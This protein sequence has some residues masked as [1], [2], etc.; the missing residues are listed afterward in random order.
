MLHVLEP[1]ARNFWK[2]WGEILDE[3]GW[4]D[5]SPKTDAEWKTVEDGAATALIVGDLL[6]S[7]SYAKEPRDDWEQQVQAF[8]TIASEARIQAMKQN[9]DA[10]FDLGERLD[11]SCDTCHAQFAPHVP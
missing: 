5:I 9:S 3:N 11:Q 6:L 1:A 4:R 10:M 7:P 8:T 2:G